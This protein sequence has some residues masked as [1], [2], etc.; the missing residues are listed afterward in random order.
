[1]ALVTVKR[2]RD[3]WRAIRRSCRVSM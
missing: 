1:M 2:T 3:A